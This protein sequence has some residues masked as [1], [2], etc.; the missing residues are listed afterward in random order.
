MGNRFDFLSIRSQIIA[1][2]PLEKILCLAMKK[3]RN[4]TKEVRIYHA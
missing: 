2:E 4:G 3:K 1:P